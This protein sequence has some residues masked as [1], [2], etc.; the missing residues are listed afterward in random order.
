MS[1]PISLRRQKLIEAIKTL[2]MMNGSPDLIESCKKALISLK[3]E[4]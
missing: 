1:D 4:K 2:E 3:D